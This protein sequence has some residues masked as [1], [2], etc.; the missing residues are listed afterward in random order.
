METIPVDS[1]PARDETSLVAFLEHCREEAR[2]NGSPRFA[3][4][5]IETEFVDPLAVLEAIREDGNPLWF[6]ERPSE[7]FALACGEASAYAEFSGPERFAEAKRFATDIFS[8]TIATGDLAPSGAGPTFTL[9]ATFE[10]DGGGGD[11][12]SPL[13]LF[14]PRWQVLRRGG[15]HFAVANAE[16][17]TESDLS[18]LAERIWAAHAKLVHLRDET[19]NGTSSSI[20]TRLSVRSEEP[21]Y[22]DAVFKALELLEG[23]TFAKIVLARKV[24]LEADHPPSAFA[25]AHR[26]RERFPDCHAFCLADHR[27]GILVGATPERLLRI[28]N[29]FLETEALAGTA[30]RGDTAGSDAKLGQ[31]LLGGEKEGREH[32]VVV[33]SILR[34]LRELGLVDCEEG[35]SRL[36]RLSNLQHVRTPVRGRMPANLHPLDVLGTLHPTPAMGGSP[37]GDAL[38]HLRELEGF[39]RGWYTGVVGWFDH[40]GNGEFVVPI[41]CGHLCEKEVTLYAGAGIL[42]GSVPANEKR[43]TDLKL[44]AMLDVLEGH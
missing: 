30:A 25:L 5:T 2:T 12:P 19:E 21:D 37:R 27:P 28:T 24:T 7:E 4:I 1:F 42:K 20:P 22:E 44:R 23:G 13:T 40:A 39:S 31:A 32:R 8:R 18:S 14:L 26:L 9:S 10:E 43:E 6:V 33:D 29:G 41:R 3:S 15:R 11:H 16:V 35:R 38:P 36:L 17:S 34:R